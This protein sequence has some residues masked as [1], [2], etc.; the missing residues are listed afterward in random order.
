MTDHMIRNCWR[1]SWFESLSGG[2]WAGCILA[3][4]RKAVDLR[5]DSLNNKALSLLDLGK[6]G[7][8]QLFLA[9]NRRLRN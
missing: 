8:R 9:S 3:S 5:A 1:K 6:S 4:N 2:N 7:G